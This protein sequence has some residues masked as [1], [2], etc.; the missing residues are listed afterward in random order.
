MRKRILVI[1]ASGDIGLAISKKIINE[2]HDLVVH[3]NSKKEPLNEI[4]ELARE[5]ELKCQLVQADLSEK[6]GVD[7]LTSQIVDQIDSIVYASG[8]SIYGLINEVSDQEID[9]LTQ[10]HIKSL[11]KV[12]N[13]FLPNM[14][15]KKSGSIV[16]VSS[17]WGQ[18][19]ASCEVLYSTTKG[20][21]NAYVMA[22][23]KELGPSNIK[24]NAVAPGAV[25]TNMLN[26]FTETDLIEIANEI[27]MS[28][29]ALPSEIANT[30]NFLISEQSS[31]ITGQI[32][33][34][35]GGWH[36]S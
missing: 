26:S 11:I 20:A 36:T 21:Q 4:L 19:G 16:V 15:A 6:N 7:V 30:V 8:F 10:L 25:K 12:V 22:L 35:N 33:G 18:I 17:I 28:R 24:V 29:L 14:V 27:P 13:Y 5:H 23:A 9:Q 32:L 31:Y 2:K 3:F 34:V 1:G